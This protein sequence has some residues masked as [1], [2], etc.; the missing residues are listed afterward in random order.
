MPYILS[1]NPLPWPPSQSVHRESLSCRPS[2]NSN[3][4]ACYRMDES[5]WLMSLGWVSVVSHTVMWLLSKDRCGW[6]GTSTW[7]SCQSGVNKECGVRI[8]NVRDAHGAVAESV[9]ARGWQLPPP[10]DRVRAIADLHQILHLRNRWS[11]NKCVG[12]SFTDFVLIPVGCIIWESR[13]ERWFS[14]MSTNVT[15]FSPRS[16]IQSRLAV[17]GTLAQTRPGRVF[18]MIRASV[19]SVVS[20]A[21]MSVPGYS[22]VGSVKPLPLMFVW[23][24]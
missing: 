24:S 19:S 14:V 7:L 2:A 22:E 6:F 16:R 12:A 11:R 8:M 21:S 1:A 15:L 5:L 10:Q 20:G 3:Y 9:E 13:S 23:G 4:R 18:S 17:I